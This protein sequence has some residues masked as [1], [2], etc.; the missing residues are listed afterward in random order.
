MDHLTISVA[1]RQ[2]TLAEQAER[3]AIYPEWRWEMCAVFWALGFACGV[4]FTLYFMER[5]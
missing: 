4:L 1:Q 2:A 3:E 5:L